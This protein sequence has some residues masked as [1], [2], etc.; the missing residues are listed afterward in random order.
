MDLKYY[1][2]IM[3]GNEVSEVLHIGRDKMN[4]LINEGQ[5]KVLKFG[6]SIRIRKQDLIEYIENHSKS[7]MEG[8]YEAN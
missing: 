4:R 2:E 5:I 7:S 8:V 3:K 6:S 1:P